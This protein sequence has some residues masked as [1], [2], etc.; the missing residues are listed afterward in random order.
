MF[1]HCPFVEFIQRNTVVLEI[2]FQKKHGGATF[3][4]FRWV[5]AEGEKHAVTPSVEGQKNR[6]FFLWDGT[7]ELFVRAAVACVDAIITNHLEIRFGDVSN[8][9]FHEIQYGKGFINKFVVFVSVVVESNRITIVFVNAG[10]GNN[11]SSEVSADVFSDNGRI[12]EVWF[13]IDIE[14]ILL[15]TV[16]RSFDFFEGVTNPCLHFI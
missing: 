13:C 15:I 12:A 2:K 9:S 3:G 1:C 5:I 16:N 4:T 10:S 8:K 14:A 11:R 6:M 7:P